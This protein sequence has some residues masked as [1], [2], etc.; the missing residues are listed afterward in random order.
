DAFEAADL[1]D[2]DEDAHGAGGLAERVGDD[3]DT[4]V[5]LRDLEGSDRLAAGGA[6]ERV[7]ELGVP[8]EDGERP[9]R[10]LGGEAEHRP[11]GSVGSYG[12][13][14]AVDLEDP[15]AYAVDQPRQLVALAGERGECAAVRLSEFG[16]GSGECVDL[17]D[18]ADLGD[19]CLGVGEANRGGAEA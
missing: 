17:G 14:P 3:E 5:V 12:A 4:A 6:L 16:K 19:A 9:A 2:V 10:D 11:R 7:S 8:E 15:L 13:S 1:G 18:A